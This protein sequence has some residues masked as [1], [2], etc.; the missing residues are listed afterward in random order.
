MFCTGNVYIIASI[1]KNKKL[2]NWIG[3][4]ILSIAVLDLASG[5]FMKTTFLFAEVSCNQSVG[6]KT[7]TQFLRVFSFTTSF[8]KMRCV[9]RLSSLFVRFQL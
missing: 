9:M 3:I 6:L 1:L 5:V 4:H 8:Y 7:S 2:Q